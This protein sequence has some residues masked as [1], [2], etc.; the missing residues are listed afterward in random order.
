MESVKKQ[1]NRYY[2]M[3]HILKLHIL[4]EYQQSRRNRFHQLN[5][6]IAAP[7]IERKSLKIINKEN[8]GKRHKTIIEREYKKS[9]TFGP[10]RQC[11]RLQKN[12]LN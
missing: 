6:Q 3:G 11:W 7:Q 8:F 9:L 10:A 5:I 12:N 4:K 1:P 2:V